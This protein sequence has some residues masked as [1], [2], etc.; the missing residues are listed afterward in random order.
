MDTNF[1]TFMA[2]Y[3]KNLSLAII[4][5]PSDYVYPITQVP[6]VVQRMREAF[7][8]GTYNKDGRAIKQTCKDLNIKYTYTAINEY[9]KN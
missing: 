1:N 4:N 2:A 9:I 7:Q 5:Y 8:K 3:E 6:V